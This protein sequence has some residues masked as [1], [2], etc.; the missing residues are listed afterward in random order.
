[1]E[2]D[3][4]LRFLEGSSM[5]VGLIKLTSQACEYLRELPVALLPL[6]MLKGISR[7]GASVMN[8]ILK[9]AGVA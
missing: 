4:S 3:R 7:L 8:S 2:D 6:K 1:M 5:S 9:E